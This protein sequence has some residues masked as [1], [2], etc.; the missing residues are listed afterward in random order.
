M[1]LTAAE[2]SRRYRQKLNANP[3]KRE[4]YLKKCRERSRKRKKVGDLTAR[5]QRRKRKEWRELQRKCRANKH[6]IQR[7][8]RLLDDNTPPPSPGPVEAIAVLPPIPP[9]TAANLQT[10][11]RKVAKRRSAS[12]RKIK[13]LEDELEKVKKSKEKYKKRYTRMRHKENRQNETIVARKYGLSPISKMKHDIKGCHNVPESVKRQLVEHNALLTQMNKNYKDMTSEVHKQMISNLLTGK[14]LK[15]Y[16]CQSTLRKK[17][18]CFAK[19]KQTKRTKKNGYGLHRNIVQF[20][21]RDD[22]TTLTPGKK[23]TVTKGKIKKQKRLLN[24]N[25]KNLHK[26]YCEEF[27]NISFATFCRHRPFWIVRP[28]LSDRDSCLCRKHSNMQFMLDVLVREKILVE[29]TV[30]SL[31][32]LVTC[33]P[34]LKDCMMNTCNSCMNKDCVDNLDR[35][36]EQKTVRVYTWKDEITEIIK[37]NKKKLIKKTVKIEQRKL[38]GIL[39]RDFNSE[40]KK[41]FCPHVFKKNHQTEQRRKCLQ[42]LAYDE[43]AVHMD[44]SENY[45]CRLSEEIQAMHFGSSHNQ[46]TLHTVVVYTEADLPKSYCTISSSKQHN[47][48]AVW[49]HLVPILEI[50]RMKG[51]D[52]V[53]FFS[54]GPS[55][56]YKNKE[57]LFLLNTFYKEMGFKYATWNFSESSHGKGAPDGVGAAVKRVADGLVSLGEDIPNAKVL[58][59]KLSNRTSVTLF[60]IEENKITEIQEKLQL[61]KIPKIKGITSVRQIVSSGTIMQSR[62]F[63]CFCKKFPATCNCHQPQELKGFRQSSSPDTLLKNSASPEETRSREVIPSIEI[64]TWLVINYNG[65]LYPGIVTNLNNDQTEVNVLHAIG[66]NKYIW[67]TK[68]DCI[69]YTQEEI[70]CMTTAPK[71]IT[72]R[73]WSFPQAEWLEYPRND[74]E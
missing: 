7:E 32:A 43:A 41:I 46:A 22:I 45:L 51:V 48:Y 3:E 73:I 67:P 15:K 20:F 50:L 61:N 6:I 58:F 66:K 29:T 16:R 65:V 56:Q 24:D 11:R 63:S 28:K 64:G 68:K 27:P 34:N 10:G 53:H 4:E 30:E 5:E 1:A 72:R 49:A 59:E 38:L 70:H 40:F 33:N 26:K 13:K 14:Y 74:D 55:S 60:Y 52:T 42:Q 71:K 21:C 9:R 54:D 35:I 19:Y 36:V 37:D 17:I 44:F 8:Q 31:C 12:Y 47:A 39:C 62:Q 23:Q 18:K 57:N 2:R 25:L 69:W